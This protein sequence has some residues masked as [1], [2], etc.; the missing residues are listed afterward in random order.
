MSQKTNV[1]QTLELANTVG[2]IGCVIGFVAIIIIAIA[3]GAGYLIDT[4]MGNERQWVTII[5]MLG[6]FPITLYAMI[7]ISLRTMAR[8]NAK[9]EELKENNAQEDN[10][11]A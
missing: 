6:S 7:Q 4:W 2:Q 8:A 9:A 11:E 5:L 1:N 3:F 10:S